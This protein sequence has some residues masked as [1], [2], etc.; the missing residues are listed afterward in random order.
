[1]AILNA[2]VHEANAE[3]RLALML[4]AIPNYP[5]PDTYQDILSILNTHPAISIIETTFPVTSGFSK[6][7]N[8]T[9]QAAHQQAA[10][11]GTGLPYLETLHGFQK[12]SI[13]VLYRE[14]F[15]T[16]GY[17]TVL[18]AMQGKIDGFLFEWL[19]PE[20]EN[21]AYSYDRYGIELVQ[22]V[23]H[24]M[25][26][27]KVARALS[28]AIEEPIVYLVAATMTGG[29]MFSQEELRSCADS[30]RLHRPK[31]KTF[32]GF[33]IRGAQDIDSVASIEGVDG[34]IIGTAFIEKMQQGAQAVADFL[35]EI[36]PALA[37][38]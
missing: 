1:M 37:R 19:I 3:G 20:V 4:Y 16:I 24:K 6:M 26:E 12:P 9:I 18:Q 15:E 27:E 8:A 25:P 17:D 31:A 33:G 36:M 14:T 23:V 34:I 21:Y 32:A 35:D 29:E 10:Q 7:A 22:C 13:S 28:L 38:R 5:N 11:F 2:A 30:I